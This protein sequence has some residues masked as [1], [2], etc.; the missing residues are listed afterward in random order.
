[1]TYGAKFADAWL[2]ISQE[3]MK[4][5]WAG[6]LGGYTPEEIARGIEQLDTRPWPPT[7]PE[8][9]MLCR[10]PIEPMGAYAEACEKYTR[11]LDGETVGWSRPEIFWAAQTVGAW[12]LKNIPYPKLEPRWKDA[13]AN[14]AR[15]PTPQPKKA[16]A[17]TSEA[18]TDPEVRARV[19]E[20]L[21]NLQ[22]KSGKNLFKPMP[23]D[24]PVRQLAAE[25]EIEGWDEV[26]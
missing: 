17:E 24:V 26:L 25:A 12:D 8:F 4:E 22:I 6:K 21:R 11:F 9:L 15:A 2:G 19:A 10:P 23:M 5:H 13:L 3:K 1:M 14:A 18:H 16:L 7:Q 20:G